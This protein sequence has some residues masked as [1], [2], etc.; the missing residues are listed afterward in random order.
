ML[1]NFDEPDGY[2]KTAKWTATRDPRVKHEDDIRNN[3]NDF[4]SS[5][6]IA[7]MPKKIISSTNQ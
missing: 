4:L 6:E 3:E 7:G 2:F 5:D 1:V